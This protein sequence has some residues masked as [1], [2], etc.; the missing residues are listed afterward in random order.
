M[1]ELGWFFLIF[2]LIFLGVM[3]IGYCNCGCSNDETE[4]A[5]PERQQSQPQS[6]QYQDQGER[7]RQS[8]QQELEQDQQ[9]HREIQN[10]FTVYSIQIED[11]PPSYMSVVAGKNDY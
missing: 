6:Q 11:L 1:M 4:T 10:H 8:R 2:L 7:H 9:L 3:W 5:L